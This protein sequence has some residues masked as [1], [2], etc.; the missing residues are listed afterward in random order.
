MGEI[1]DMPPNIKWGV[2]GK[3]GD[4][5]ILIHTRNN[6]MTS[7]TRIAK[8]LF[9]LLQ[10]C[11]YRHHDLALFGRGHPTTPGARAQ[12]S[13]SERFYHVWNV[14]RHRILALLQTTRFES[15]TRRVT[16][17]VTTPT[18]EGTRP[19]EPPRWKLTS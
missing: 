16:E 4:R 19:K 10:H 17:G 18:L 15:R 3:G 1:G 7:H 2:V 11:K 12:R 6:R 8:Y 9:V 13:A 5:T 14:Y